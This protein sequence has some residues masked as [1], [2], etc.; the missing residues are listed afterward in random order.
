MRVI[1]AAT[2]E[3]HQVA[4]TREIPQPERPAAI[5]PENH[6]QQG[7][8]PHPLGQYFRPRCGS[9]H[10]RHAHSSAPSRDGPGRA[11]ARQQSRRSPGALS[12]AA[13]HP[14]GWPRSPA[15]WA[16]SAA[17]TADQ[18]TNEIICPRWQKA[19]A[20]GP[21]PILVHGRQVCMQ[22]PAHLLRHQNCVGDVLARSGRIPCGPQ[23]QHR[24]SGQVSAHEGTCSQ[25]LGQSHP[26]SLERTHRVRHLHP[27]PPG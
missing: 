23:P 6:T 9:K 1:S 15:S 12:P 10:A 25:T 3:Q 5:R 21:G 8:S 14:L 7:L 17:P 11:Y 24:A 27:P 18:T 22:Q 2:R 19:H 20:L 26:P 13:D 16:Y 4:R